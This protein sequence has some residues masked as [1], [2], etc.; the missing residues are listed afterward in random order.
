M[1]RRT[2]CTLTALLAATL[3]TVILAG[4]IVLP[5]WLCRG[6]EWEGPVTDHFDGKFFYNPEPGTLYKT[7]N[8]LQ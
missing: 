7:S 4:D 2:K 1:N 6:G 3:G 8:L 5:G